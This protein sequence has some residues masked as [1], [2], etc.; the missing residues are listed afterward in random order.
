MF[1]KLFILPAIALCMGLTSFSYVSD[2]SAQIPGSK[3]IP[4]LQDPTTGK[5]LQ[6]EITKTHKNPTVTN[7]TT[8]TV[9]RT[10]ACAGRHYRPTTTI[11]CSDNPLLGPI[12]PKDPGLVTQCT[13]PEL[14]CNCKEIPDRLNEDRIKQICNT[15][16][17]EDCKTIE[18]SPN[19][20]NPGNTNVI[21]NCENNTATTQGG[22][23]PR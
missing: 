3:P 17:N 11:Y 10:K 2:A 20:N 18:V 13:F 6:P 14:N 8:P 5:N 16:G 4:G 1:K 21:I 12:D 22:N 23:R 9:K 7:A 15:P 19:N